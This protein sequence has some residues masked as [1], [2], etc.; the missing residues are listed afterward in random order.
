[1]KTIL[2]ISFFELIKIDLIE[3]SSFPTSG[4]LKPANILLSTLQ[5][6]FCQRNQLTTVSTIDN[7]P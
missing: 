4:T 2:K 1:M 6:I 3:N 5:T 7:P